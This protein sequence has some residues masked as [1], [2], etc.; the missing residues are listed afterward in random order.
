MKPIYYDIYS[1]LPSS[2]KSRLFR[3]QFI[4]GTFSTFR[5]RKLEEVAKHEKLPKHT[6]CVE[7]V[8]AWEEKQHLYIQTELCHTRFVDWEDL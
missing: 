5:K 3:I 8:K 2:H 4:V 1:Y 7:F 6:N